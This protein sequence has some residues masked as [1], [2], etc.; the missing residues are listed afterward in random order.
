M[1][2]ELTL[3]WMNIYPSMSAGKAREMAMEQVDEVEN[4][5]D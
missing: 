4:G 5:E 1:V 3:F 2:E